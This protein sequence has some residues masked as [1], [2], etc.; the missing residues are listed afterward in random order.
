[1][2]GRLP[3]V[4][5]L[6]ETILNSRCNLI[7]RVHENSKEDK[8]LYIFDH[9]DR[10]DTNVICVFSR[11]EKCRTTYESL[12]TNKRKI[13]YLKNKKVTLSELG[14]L[15]I[16]TPER[17]DATLAFYP[18]HNWLSEFDCALFYDSD[19]LLNSVRGNILE[20]DM[21]RLSRFNP[22]VRKVLTFSSVKNVEHLAVW[23][24][25]CLIDYTKEGK[26]E[27]DSS[28]LEEEDV[29]T[30]SLIEIVSSSSRTLS[31]LRSFFELSFAYFQGK[32]IP[33][34]DRILSKLIDYNLILKAKNYYP[35]SLGKMCVG[36]RLPI[37]HQLWVISELKQGV[38]PQTLKRNVPKSDVYFY[39]WM[40]HGIDSISKL[41]GV[42]RERIH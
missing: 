34:L 41:I 5:S 37:T 16:C 1:M 19:L 33:S 3:E 10:V 12:K 6:F 4:G 39:N 25:S 36:L 27:Y 28:F 9:L 11:L 20:A 31:E 23:T 8:F 30:Q 15:L 32:E 22:F 18:S 26:E 21:I 7:I 17:L 38:S 42:K 29:V 35:T 14:N 13:L 2:R 24:K 40:C